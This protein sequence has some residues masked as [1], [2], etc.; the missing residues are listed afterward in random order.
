MKTLIWL[1]K[2]LESW[3]QRTQMIWQINFQKQKTIKDNVVAGKV[4]IPFQTT[5]SSVLLTHEKKPV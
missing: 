2:T 3:F 4:K 5:W 1:L